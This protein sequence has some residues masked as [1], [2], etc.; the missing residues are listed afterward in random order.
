MSLDFHKL[1]TVSIANGEVT[2]RIPERWGV[3][4]HETDEGR[5]GCYEKDADGNE[6]DTGTVWVGIYHYRGKLDGESAGGCDVTEVLAQKAAERKAQSDEPPALESEIF[7]VD[8]GHCWYH[9]CDAEQ[10]GDM[11]RFWWF[12]FFLNRGGRG[13]FISI[14]LVLTHAQMDDPEFAELRDIMCREISAA[15]LDPFRLD[16]EDEAERDLAPLVRLNC[17]GVVR[18]PVPHVFGP[19]DSDDGAGAG[20]DDGPPEVWFESGVRA[21]LDIMLEN[22]ALCA[23]NDDTPVS[24]DPDSYEKVLLDFVNLPSDMVHTRRMPNGAVA[25]SAGNPQPARKGFLRFLGGDGPPTEARHEWWAMYF[26]HGEA[27][28]LHVTLR[29]SVVPGG[30]PPPSALVAY[31]HRAVCRAEFLEFDP[32]E[33]H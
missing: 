18:L 25:Y 3:W 12:Q 9:V 2:F 16:D 33:A 5:W 13:A 27:K 8:Q 10:D 15:F 26:T 22:V 1:K 21:G 24:V 11:L 14:N 17:D 31:M 28:L 23:E 32:P 7:P 20:G 4:P 30:G 29:P 19:M 6:P